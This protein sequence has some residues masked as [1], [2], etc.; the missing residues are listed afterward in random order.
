VLWSFTNDIQKIQ[1][2]RPRISEL[3]MHERSSAITQDI[4]CN[5]NPKNFYVLCCFVVKI[6]FV[7]ISILLA[8]RTNLPIVLAID[9]RTGLECLLESNCIRDVF[10]QTSSKIF[11][12]AS[13]IRSSCP[14]MSID[15]FQCPTNENVSNTTLRTLGDSVLFDELMLKELEAKQ[16][17][18]SQ[19]VESEQ[20]RNVEIEAAASRVLALI[21][22]SSFK[23][24]YGQDFAYPKSI[25]C[26]LFTQQ[27]RNHTYAFEAFAAVATVT[28]NA[29]K[30]KKE[31]MIFHPMF[32]NVIERYTNS[33]AKPN[34]VLMETRN[35]EFC[36]RLSI[37]VE[38]VPISVQASLGFGMSSLRLIRQY[39]ILYYIW[40]T[41]RHDLE[42]KKCYSDQLIGIP[43]P[44][45]F[46]NVCGN[47][48]DFEFSEHSINYY[49]IRGAYVPV[50]SSR[51]P[52]AGKGKPLG[53]F[54]SYMS[55]EKLGPSLAYMADLLKS[56]RKWFKMSTALKLLDQI[57]CRLMVLHRYGIILGNLDFRY[58]NFG[59]REAI[60]VLYVSSFDCA[61]QAP[62]TQRP[63]NYFNERFASIGALKG[64][65]HF[66]NDIETAFYLFLAMLSH[67]LPWDQK[68]PVS[69]TPLT[70]QQTQQLQQPQFDGS[71]EVGGN[72]RYQ[73]TLRTHLD[74]RTKLWDTTSW[75]DR[76]LNSYTLR[77][78]MKSPAL[79]GFAFDIIQM[80]YQKTKE[81]ISCAS[82]PQQ[83]FMTNVMTPSTTANNAYMGI[84][85]VIVSFFRFESLSNNLRDATCQNKVDQ[86]LATEESDGRAL[87]DLNNWCW[88]VF[89]TSFMSNAR[90]SRRSI[91]KF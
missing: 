6:K 89:E 57:L 15:Q 48:Y 34:P 37:L 16:Q 47:E 9:G 33:R 60:N 29:L 61:V 86:L 45:E 25:H 38:A 17:L 20:L 70:D 56:Q 74:E 78:Q 83:D 12:A 67:R 81:A 19:S 72:T 3:F 90:S 4:N 23:R 50:N 30:R 85:K 73:S 66:V 71:W 75:I 7:K 13:A 64:V 82:I 42:V 2:S 35:S 65:A 77:N 27:P 32:E 88:N 58:L 10:P 49:D 54:L 63:L 52:G 21:M 22:D 79:E 53:S 26:Y 8:R 5:N 62:T 51:I 80:V 24:K 46:V 87:W 43:V 40:E 39:E 11:I 55:M 44:F 41:F 91:V 28:P 59:V 14:T 69:E 1:Q 31:E 68:P 76:M 36:Y 84:R 18:E